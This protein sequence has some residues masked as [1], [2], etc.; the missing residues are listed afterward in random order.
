MKFKDWLL[1][2]LTTIAVAISLYG[3]FCC[4]RSGIFYCVHGIDFSTTKYAIMQFI[5]AFGSLLSS[6][7]LTCFAIRTYGK[8]ASHATRYT[9]EQY[10]SRRE[11]KRAERREKKRQRLQEELERMSREHESEP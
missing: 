4:I 10:R 3:A 8:H 11:A 6:G 7:C 5:I 9:Y 1:L 2:F